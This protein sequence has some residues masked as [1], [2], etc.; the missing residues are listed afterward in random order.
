LSKWIALL[1]RFNNGNPLKKD[2]ITKI[3][4]FFE[5]YWEHN[6]MQALKSEE[7]IRFVSELPNNVQSEIIIDYL[8]NDFLYRYRFYFQS[9]KPLKENKLT[10]AFK[11]TSIR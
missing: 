10:E 11:T 4:D 7:D 9:V 8:W 6:R 3:E 1:T 2:L 5:Y